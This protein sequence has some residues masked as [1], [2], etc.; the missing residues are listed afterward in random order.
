MTGSLG[1]VN[2]RP[3]GNFSGYHRKW[4]AIKANKASTFVIE[5]F[6]HLGGVR[7]AGL[8]RHEACP[9]HPLQARGYQSRLPRRFRGVSPT[10]FAG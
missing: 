6:G 10:I 7:P 5:P 1:Q 8:N 4:D 9:K 2:A 3:L